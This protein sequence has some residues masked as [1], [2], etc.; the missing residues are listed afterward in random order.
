MKVTFTPRADELHRRLLAEN[1]DMRQAQR[2]YSKLAIKLER[3]SRD[4]AGELEAILP[5]AKAWADYHPVG[6]NQLFVREVER[7]LAKRRMA[8]HE[9]HDPDKR[10]KII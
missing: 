4:L 8:I 1:A 9:A 2:A 6:N 7:C 5:M 10:D 3:E